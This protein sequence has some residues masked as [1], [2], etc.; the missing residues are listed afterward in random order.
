M[1]AA[2]A[3]AVAPE[4][5]AADESAEP[6]ADAVEPRAD[7][8]PPPASSPAWSPAPSPA[9]SWASQIRNRNPDPPAATTYSPNPAA[10]DSAGRWGRA[11]AGDSS[12][13]RGD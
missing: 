8:L 7:A 4:R 13:D 10:D 12:E 9:G 11:A 1:A 5:P 6:P 2:R 3:A